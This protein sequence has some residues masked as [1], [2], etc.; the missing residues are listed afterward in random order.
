[1][2][3]LALTTS[4]LVGATSATAQASQV[5]DPPSPDE[6][7]NA[8]ATAHNAILAD[9]AALLA[10]EQDTFTLTS[11]VE[12]VRGLQYLT[13][14]RKHAGLPVYGGDVVVATDASGAVVDTV[15]TGQRTKIG[16]GTKAKVTAAQA[17][18]TA[19]AKVAR[20]E[21]V[22]TPVLSVHATTT[23]PRL[24]WEVLVTGANATG[25]ETKLHVYVDA[26]TGKVIDDWDEVRD[27][28]GNSYYVGTVT[29]DTSPSYT[30]RDPRRSGVACGGQNGT[31]YTKT[32]DTWGNG[33]GT[34]LETACVDA[35]YAAQ[36]E[37]DMLSAWLGRNGINGQGGGYPAR[38]GL[39]DVNAYWN[40]QYGSFGH[41]SANSQQL[42]SMDVVGHEFGHGIFQFTSGGSGSGNETGGMNESTGDIFGALTEAYANNPN[43]P[44]DY[45]VGEEV[46]LSGSGPIRNMYN[47]SALGHPNCY[48]ASIPNTE[49]HAAAGPQNH[50]FYLV[51]EGTNPSG[52]PASTRCDNGAAIT[53]IGIR[54]AGEVFMSALNTKTQPW[55]HAKAR[56]A[57]LQAA[58]TLY[59]GSCTEFNVVK[60]AW[61]GVSVR[62]QSGE[63]TCTQGSNDFSVN[64][65][66]ASGSVTPGQS[67]TTTVSTTVTGG[68]AQS[69][70]LRTGTLPA[71]VTASFSPATITAGQ[72]STLTI[73]TSASSPQ[74]THSIAIT[75]DGA[76]VDRQATYNLQI[77]Q[78]SPNDYSFGVT[79]SSASV[80]A[81][82]SATATVSTQ[83]TAGQ[84]QSIALSA[85]NVP[86]GVTVSFSPSTITAGQSS[87]V[88]FATTSGVTPSTYTISLNADGAS[89]DHSASFSLTVGGGQGTTWQTYTAY[90]AGQTV[91]YQGTSYRCLQ[92]HTSLPG[93]EPPNTPALWQPV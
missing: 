71:G 23:T 42:T 72:S 4:S 27:G 56:V 88:T 82:Q 49:V 35:L 46:N 74:G 64:L 63:P 16:I 29:I 92:A 83:V 87:T 78:S 90:T 65:N 14:A 13:Y 8:I 54:K 37:W 93:W 17:A 50:W 76:D 10:S 60:N 12:G 43:D 20:V 61:D 41:N 75:A 73:T 70:T 55:T 66:P 22:A 30:M 7:R 79:P 69:I 48:S 81:G 58:K 6:R 11:T 91:T 89:A 84:A 45:L 19:R 67:T 86:A 28:T 47:P 1:M 59:P 2:L 9:S 57:T 68:S 18:V 36:R 31:P 51:A 34:N 25:H 5:A 24:A 52:K 80:Q 85:S 44:P 77:G 32:T 62:A 40:G 15:A 53:G 38:V 39:A 33:S 21:T 3:A 26:L